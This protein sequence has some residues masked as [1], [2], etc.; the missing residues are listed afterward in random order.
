M[1]WL[2]VPRGWVESFGDIARFTAEC[3]R[4]VYGGRVFRFFGEV[5]RQSGL[6]ILSS[7]IVIWGL[8]ALC[9]ALAGIVALV[10]GYLRGARVS[11]R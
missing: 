2:A 4:E 11:A 6:L 3:F 10:V 7:T 8:G 5:L 9:F 1:S